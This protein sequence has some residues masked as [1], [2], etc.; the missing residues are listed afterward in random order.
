MSPVRRRGPVE[1]QD[2]RA[3]ARHWTTGVA[4]LTAR[5][6]DEVFA[7]TVS[8]FGTLS[9]D[10][11]LVSVAVAA[12]SPLAAAVRDSGRFAVSVLSA[13]QEAVGRRF[14]TPGAGRALG[15]FTT[16]PMRVEATGAPV[17]DHCLAWFDCRLHAILPGGDHALLVGEVVAADGAPGEPLLYHDGRYRALA[18]PLAD[19]AL[20]GPAPAL[21][22]KQP[23][24]KQP[25]DKQLTD[26]Q[27]TDAPTMTSTGA[28][29]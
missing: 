29:A 23:T 22:D 6:G 14:A 20:T 26:K 21:T 12:R 10:P 15:M 9:L 17:V 4:V 16:V 1:P 13:R 5:D 8:S 3:A 2:V 24:N 11:P 25:A 27:P 28:T 19:P 18:H 7:K